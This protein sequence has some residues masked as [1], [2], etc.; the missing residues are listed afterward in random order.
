MEEY[1]EYETAPAIADKWHDN[2]VIGLCHGCKMP[3][4]PLVLVAQDS[5]SSNKCK[6]CA[7]L[8]NLNYHLKY[9]G[10]RVKALR[11]KN[12]K[13][14]LVVHFAFWIVVAYAIFMIIVSI[15]H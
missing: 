4:V 5:S 9:N 15:T 3:D 13:T 12:D 7:E 1:K 10:E 11:K 14:P 6:W 8:D 2:S